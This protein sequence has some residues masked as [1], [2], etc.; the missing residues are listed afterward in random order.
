VPEWIEAI[1]NFEKTF[2]TEGLVRHI[3]FTFYG[4][5]LALKNEPALPLLTRAELIKT[6]FSWERQYRNTHFE[7][8]KKKPQFWK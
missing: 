5:L 3:I 7:S 1:D 2:S 6:C 4:H 8:R